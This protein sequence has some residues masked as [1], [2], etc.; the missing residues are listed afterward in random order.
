MCSSDLA[1]GADGARSVTAATGR[2]LRR[3]LAG[4]WHVVAIL[5]VLVA[6]IVWLI[7]PTDGGRFVLNAT[8]LTALTWLGAAVAAFVVRAIVEA[9]FRATDNLREQFP[10][11]KPRANQYL[12]LLTLACAVVVYGIAFLLMLQIWGARSLDWFATPLGRRVSAALAVIGI[13]MAIALAFWELGNVVLERWVGRPAEGGVSV[14]RREAR[15]RTLMP[16]M[17]LLLMAVLAL[18]VGFVVLSELGI[19][20]APLL[21]GA[22]AL[23]LAVGL[24]AQGMIK[25]LVTGVSMILTDTLAIGDFVTLADKSGYVE[26]ISISSVQLRSQDGTLHTVPFGNIAVVS[27]QTKDYAFAAFDIGVDYAADLD[28]ANAIIAATAAELRRDPV[29]GAFVLGELDLMGVDAFTDR[30]VVIKARVKTLPGKQW[31]V[32]R[33][34]NGR[35]KRAFDAAGIDMPLARQNVRVIAAPPVPS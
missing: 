23:G 35:L 20:I 31:D 30:A 24:G 14:D 18:F 11:L 28:R 22:G 2:R 21:A 33:A 13:A 5:Y 7:R 25:N 3:R 4:L 34:F 10:T 26:R 27:N 16:I 15:V 6:M 8:A 9:I 17:Q 32:A 29:I 1:Q 19:S 12:R